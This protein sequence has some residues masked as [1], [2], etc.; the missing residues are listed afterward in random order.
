MGRDKMLKPVGLPCGVVAIDGKNLGT[1][2]HGAGGRAH[3]R[4][5]NDVE[6]WAARGSDDGDYWL[7]PVLRATLVS[8]PQRPCIHQSAIEPGTG[9]ATSFVAAIDALDRAYGRSRLFEV[10]TADAGLCSLANA[11]HVVAAGY[12]Y[13]FGLKGNQKALFSEAQDRLLD[14]TKSTR[15]EVTTEWETRGSSQIQRQLWRSIEFG[16]FS[17]CA[18]KWEHLRQIWLVRQ[19]TRTKGGFCHFED[20]FFVTSMPRECANA[21]EV[22]TVVRSH[23][24]IE[25]DTFNSLDLQWAEDDAP[26]A[27]RGN[28][29][30]VLGL[31]R[32][33]AY[34]LA[35]H[36]R[37]RHLCKCDKGWS[38]QYK[39][40]PWR[41]V[42]DHI[43][44]AMFMTSL[45]HGVLTTPPG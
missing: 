35:Q 5:G 26:W 12:Q 14:R 10:I 15:P 17:N 37:H 21:N 8:A 45:R 43:K 28:A 3:H 18:G 4:S 44:E 6:K 33:M 9:E 31:L 41:R 11:D 16:Q 7:A 24:R 29:V 27:T 13:V 30:W 32:L 34:N 2:N 25:N 36:L 42:F 23:W 19:T 40:L 38:A 22:L 1:L 20:R 39:P